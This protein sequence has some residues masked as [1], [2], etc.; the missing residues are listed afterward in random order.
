MCR[1]VLCSKLLEVSRD[2]LHEG[3]YEA[4]HDKRCIDREEVN[5]TR[6]IQT[7]LYVSVKLYRSLLTS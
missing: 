6:I 4:Y 7:T 2:K 5:K 3:L 1:Q